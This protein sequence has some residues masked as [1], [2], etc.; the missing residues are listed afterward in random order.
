[1]HILCSRWLREYCF[2]YVIALYPGYTNCI[3]VTAKGLCYLQAICK[4]DCPVASSI[5]GLAACS[6]RKRATSWNLFSSAK[7]KGVRLL[8]PG[9]LIFALLV[10]NNSTKFSNP[11]FA[12]THN[13]VSLLL[14]DVLFT[15]ALCWIKICAMSNLPKHMASCMGVPNKDQHRWVRVICHII[16][17]NIILVFQRHTLC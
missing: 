15:S 12:D 8:S 16:T 9:W 6:I 14:L 4:G 3:N 17:K 1:M 7:C 2:Y 10:T 13:A 11:F 5:L